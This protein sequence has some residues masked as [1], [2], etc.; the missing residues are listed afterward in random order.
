MSETRNKGDEAELAVAADLLRRGYKVAIPYGQGWD[1]DL[2]LVRNGRFER[3]Q[4]KYAVERN[5]VIPIRATSQSM[6]RGKIHKLKIY[7]P[8][9]IDWIAIYEKTSG[10][11]Y[12]IP[13]S[14]LVG[15]KGRLQ[16][17]TRS[18]NKHP[19]IRWAKDYETI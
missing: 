13:S 18:K 8:D 6:I 3:V 14:V 11:C 2:I 9:E 16:M 10:T 7:G 17:R 19:D 12:Y 15:H 4:V 5:G 1:Y